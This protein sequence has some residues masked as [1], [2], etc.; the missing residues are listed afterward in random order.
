[1]VAG[2]RKGKMKA[3][4]KAKTIAS[5][6]EISPGVMVNPNYKKGKDPALDKVLK[7]LN[8]EKKSIKIISSKFKINNIGFINS[9]FKYYEKQGEL[10]FSSS[11]ELIIENQQEFARKFQLDFDKAK[12]VKKIY[13]DLEKIINREEFSVSNISIN[14]FNENKENENSYS[15]S[16]I[17]ILK[18]VLRSLII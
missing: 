9:N 17:Q 2:P 4:K 7:D 13:F 12:K 8:I 5:L 6:K 1:M 15:I 18:S 3:S 11:N 16:S 10:I 14:E